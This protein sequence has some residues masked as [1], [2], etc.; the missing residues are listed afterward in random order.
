MSFVF[1]CGC[2]VKLLFATGTVGGVLNGLVYPILAYL[3][4]SSFSDISA[5]SNNGLSQ[6][7]KLAYTFMI[8]GA[9]ALVAA[10]VQSWA[11]EMVAYHGSQSFR[12]Q[13]FKALLRQDPSFFDVYD[14]GGVAAQVGPNSNKY[15]R[16]IGRKFGEGVQFMTTGIF[17]LA[18]AF[19]ASWRVAFVVLAV[20][21]FVTIAALATM[22]INQTK[23]S[24]AAQTYKKAGGIAY[25]SVSAI[26]TVLSLNAVTEMVRQYYDATQLAFEESVSVLV[27]QG[28]AFG[29]MMGSFLALYA[30]LTLF[31]AFLL[32]RD[33]ED[34][35]CDPSDGVEGNTTCDNAGPDVF[36]AML[37][38]AFAAQ[39]VSQVGNFFESFTT[40]RVAAHEALLAI[41]RKPGAESVTIYKEEG[42]DD[43]GTTTHSRK[44]KPERDIENGEK[45]RIVKAILPAYEIDSSSDTGLK[46]EDISGNISI[47]DVHFSYPTRP[48]DPILNGLNLEIAAGQTVALVGPS[49]GGKSTVVAMLERFYD[50]HLGSIEVDGVNI[51]D[52][53]VKHL[54]SM[55]G[56]VGQEPTL[57]ATTIR[58]NIQYG[59]PSATQEQIE[60]AARMANAHDFIS[61]FSDGYDTQVR[62]AL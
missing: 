44:S 13:W 3:F 17:G 35:G 37:G 47:K 41:N 59:N 32:Y 27:K 31:G 55:I 43:I 16:G 38:V 57:F 11:F 8:V 61:S 53:N 25:S 45:D 60:A 9:Y 20:I 22:R 39:G 33:V 21:P 50:P 15:R 62:S 2:R 58:G 14:V 19:W 12:L 23:G 29:G 36:G 51:K 26:K 49:G 42:D 1:D 6:I 56:Y 52:L 54:R 24:R 40:A 30:V 10:T 7:R 34:T 48:G 4:S 46:P 28:L 18:Y 5:A